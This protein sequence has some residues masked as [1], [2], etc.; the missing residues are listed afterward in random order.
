MSLSLWFLSV[1]AEADRLKGFRLKAEGRNSK[2][3]VINP[4]AFSLNPFSLNPF[5]LFT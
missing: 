3:E 2:I 5:S 4:L 1:T